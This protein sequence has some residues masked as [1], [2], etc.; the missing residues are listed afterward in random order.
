M[1]AK[2]VLK[3]VRH[4]RARFV[5]AMLGVAAAAGLVVWSLG[6]TVTA[7]AQCRE[8]ARQITA[9]FTCW[10]STSR[11]GLPMDRAAMGRLFRPSREQLL[12]TIPTNVLAA[13]Q[14]VAGVERVEPFRTMRA[15]LDYRPDGRVMQGPPLMA[16]LAEAPTSGCP[17]AEA[18]MTGEWPRAADPEP[19]VAVCSSVFAPRRLTPPPLGTPLVLLTPSGTITVRIGAI[20][21][22]PQTVNGFPTMFVSS[23]TMQRV[24][25]DLPYD[26]QPNLILCQ[27][28]GNPARVEAA[29]SAAPGATPVCS[30]AERKTIESTLSSDKLQ[31][32]K[33]QA[34]LLLTLSVMAALCMLVNALNM[35]V[36]QKLRTMALLR[37]VGMTAPQVAQMV[38]LEGLLLAACGWALGMLG[39]WG[40]LEVFVRRT[41][42][43]FPEGVALGWITPAGTAAGVAFLTALA[44]FWPCRRAMRIRPLDVLSEDRGHEDRI[45]GGRAAIGFVLLFPMLILA[46]PLHISAMLRSVLLLTVGMPLHLIG[47]LL[48]LPFFVR[49]VERG[50]TPAASAMLGLDPRILHRR[51]SRHAGRTAGM[52]LTLAV[53][54]GSYVAIHIWGASMLAPFLPSPEF[55]DVIVSI[56]PNGVS[57][58]AARK[59]SSMEGV[60]DGK[61]LAIEAAQFYI[62]EDVSTRVVRVSGG[63]PANP[64]VLLFGAEPQAAFG[65]DHPLAPFRFV[66][67]DRRKA[68]EALAGG[69]A[70]VI[71]RMFAR[72][73]GM[74]VGDSLGIIKQRPVR[75]RSGW[76]RRDGS[77]DAGGPPTGVEGRAL[78]AT[79]SFRIVG[80][81]DLNWHMITSRAQMRGRGAISMGTMGPV[82]VS[83]ADARRLSGN[84]DTTCFLWLNLSDA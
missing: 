41:P 24:M 76:G 22:F 64:N 16:V 44:L 20:I 46:L 4:E 37:T 1:I 21:D 54:L 66:Q 40:V 43:A 12:Q 59:I 3:N 65:G 80:V 7:M 58:E 18:R 17:Y 67:G 23:G 61:C 52:V 74:G 32:F 53:G 60:A 84:A 49:L 56:L 38:M 63:A 55:P 14:G 75:R 79:E 78:P 29:V 71:T 72:E 70:C 26:G 73:T 30:F 15:T 45:S 62:T 68:A 81:V 82:F 9:P 10:V 2:L 5:T 35:G 77:G 42:D 57:Q 83:E 34:P 50:V 69:G 31:N 11:V 19:E 27:T 47:L 28:R 51:I 6:L 39:G 48:C 33:R 25:G 36:E 8:K 13:V